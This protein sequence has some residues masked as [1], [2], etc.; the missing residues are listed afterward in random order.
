VSKVTKLPS[1]LKEESLV[2]FDTPSYIF[3]QR[4]NLNP[5]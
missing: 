2:T 3:Y 4:F 5:S 1:F